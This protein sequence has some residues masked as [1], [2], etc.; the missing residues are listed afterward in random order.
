MLGD[1]FTAVIVPKLGFLL[2][3]FRNNDRLDIEAQFFRFHLD[4][5]EGNSLSILHTR[6]NFIKLR[7]SP[8]ALLD[9]MLLEAAVQ[10]IRLPLAHVAQGPLRA[11]SCVRYEKCVSNH[12]KLIACQV[13]CDYK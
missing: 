9:Q 13:P 11:F 3:F 12:A 10:I 6:L 4:E 7:S 5:G 1:F 8:R 2:K